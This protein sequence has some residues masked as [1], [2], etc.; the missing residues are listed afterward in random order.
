M[1]ELPSKD[2]HAHDDDNKHDDSMRSSMGVTWSIF[3]HP[4]FNRRPRNYTG[5]ADPFYLAIR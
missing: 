3:F 5:S 1:I 4:D 2:T